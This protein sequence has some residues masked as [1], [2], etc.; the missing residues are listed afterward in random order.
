[1]IGEA[2]VVAASRPVSLFTRFWPVA[3]LAVAAIVNLA[4]MGIIGY[5]SF[6]LAVAAF[7]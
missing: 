1:M 5:G 4:W 6:N 7:S 2:Q 3:G